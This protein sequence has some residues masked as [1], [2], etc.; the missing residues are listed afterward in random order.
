MATTSGKRTSTLSEGQ[1]DALMRGQHVV[2]T[3][4]HHGVDTGR[5]VRFVPIRGRI[6]G[7][8]RRVQV[9]FVNSAQPEGA[10]EPD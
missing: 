7:Q 10:A 2:T 9:N 8:T 6:T 3:K 1:I 5:L 4:V